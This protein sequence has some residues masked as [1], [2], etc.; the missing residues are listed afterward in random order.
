MSYFAGLLK[1]ESEQKE[2][3]CQYLD[4]IIIILTLL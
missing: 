4:T 2:F 1:E 3:N